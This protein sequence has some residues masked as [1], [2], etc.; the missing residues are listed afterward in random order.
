MF[1]ESG[2]KGLTPAKIMLFLSS[3]NSTSSYLKSD[4]LDDGT[5][6]GTS[7]IDGDGEGA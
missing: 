2:L 4:G 6:D 5:A 7:D 3:I 1:K